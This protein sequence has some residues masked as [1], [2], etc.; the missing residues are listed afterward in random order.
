MNFEELNTYLLSKEGASFDYPFD[1]TT[2]VYR[3]G[4]KMFA[5]TSEEHPVRVNLK[6][7]PLYAL[8]LRSLYEGVVSGYHM[9]KKHWNT[10]S[11]E[12]S[13]VDEE[14]IKELIDHSYELVF[15]SL[16]KKQKAHLLQ[17]CP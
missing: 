4:D 10:V 1:E 15:S 6:C 17:G 12:D 13:D 11:V 5:L 8:E 14:T 7:D 2:R 16:T 3:V 9:N